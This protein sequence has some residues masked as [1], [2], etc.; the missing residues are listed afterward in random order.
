MKEKLYGQPL[1]EDV[2]GNLVE[3]HVYNSQ[4]SKALVLSFHGGSG[5]GKNYV[6]TM[7]TKHLYKRGMQSKFVKLYV[8]TVEFQST[9]STDINSYRVR[10]AFFT[11]RRIDASAILVV[12][13]SVRPSHACFMTKRKACTVDTLIPHE[14]VA[15]LVLLK[16]TLVG[17]RLP[18]PPKLRA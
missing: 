13:L 14:R 12:I 4:P 16:P 9:S 11:A 10:T 5:V 15:P 6:S 17:G 8:A 2:V 3:A 1:V 7:M 18:L